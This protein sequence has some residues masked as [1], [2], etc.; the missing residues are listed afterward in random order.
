M[1]G[2]V[3]AIYLGDVVH[4]RLRP[5]RHRL[6][7][8]L[9]ML[10]LDLDE[11]PSLS[12]GVRF[13][14]TER[15]ALFGFR[16]SDH[17]AG[18]ETPLRSQVE[19]ALKEAGLPLE[20]GPIRVL[21]MPRVLGFAFNPISVFFCHDRAGALR[22]VLYEVNNTFGQRHT[23][24]IP[25]EPGS[26]GIVRQSCEKR[27]Y[28]SPFLEMDMQYHFRLAIPGA[29]VAVAIEA[30]DR[31]GPILCASFSGKVRDLTAANL[32]RLLPRYPLLG[33]QVLG[34]I[35]WEALKLWGKGLRIKPRP[36]PPAEAVSVARTKEA[37]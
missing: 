3:S 14:S 9:P 23:Y 25:A 1:R 10:L 35:H 31:E 8:P 18:D 29:R 4:T 32:L 24:L 21:C 12:R 6:H 22:A 26:D 16:G 11:L 2:F 37:A 7:Y 28:V 34:G 33:L 5:M 19:S 17:L 27:F 15:F 20:G 30:R 36:S 13:F